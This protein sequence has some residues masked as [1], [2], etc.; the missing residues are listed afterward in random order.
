MSDI[1]KD[2]M[3]SFVS[4]FA[5]DT[6]IGHAVNDDNDPNTLQNDLNKIY[7]WTFENMV[8]NDDKFESINYGR[9]IPEPDFHIY[10]TASNREI[11]RTLT[12]KDLGVLTDDDGRFITQ[13][14][15]TVSRA[16]S[17]SGFIFRTF[18]TRG[19]KPMLTLWKTLVLPVLDYC[20]QL[21]S[22]ST[23]G[24]IQE[25]E[26]VQ[27]SFTYRISGM[28]NFNYWERLEK[29]RLYSLER[30][31]ERYQ[32]IYIWKII[33]GLVPNTTGL[34][35][36][37]NAR[38][39]CLCD[40]PDYKSIPNKKIQHLRDNRFKVRGARLFNTLTIEL[41]N[42]KNCSAESFKG[43]LDNFLSSVP[44]QPILPGYM[45]QYGSNSLIYVA[46]T[47]RGH[48]GHRMDT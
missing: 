36:T 1:D 31:R 5:D 40:I 23:K 18:A 12:V 25:L 3:N 8:F 38:R 7:R 16:K 11:S 43:Q 24:L 33:N 4:S 26:A 30:R 46:N 35:C 19:V 41:R 27:R 44:D 9:N 37:E 20:C 48:G 42:K 13:I 15:K 14:R 34:T 6:K 28:A 39:G 32:I 45:N 10:T 21:W 2:I 29:L 22:P 17:L 47:V